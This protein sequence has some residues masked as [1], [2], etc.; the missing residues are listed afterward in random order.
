[1]SDADVVARWRDRALALGRQGWRC[2]GCGAVA[3]VRRRRCAACGGEAIA[4]APL[5]RTGVVRA[6]SNAG[7]V[8]EHLDQVSGRKAAVWIELE[9]GG[10]MACLLAHADSVSLLGEVRGQPVR[11]AVR[12][13]V[14]GEG[15]PAAPIPYGI[16]AAL[17]L[18][19]RAALK[20]KQ[21]AAKAAKDPKES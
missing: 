3:L 10:A 13:Q 8:V 6:A 14:L 21:A 9:G 12:K 16:K 19:T 18:E 17:A 5:A 7:A 15:D 4:R 20:A 11:L 2:D 1:M